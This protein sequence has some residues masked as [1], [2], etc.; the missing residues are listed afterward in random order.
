MDVGG[1]ALANRLDVGS[2]DG[3]QRPRRGH[4]ERGRL[5]QGTDG[6]RGPAWHGPGAPRSGTR[7][8]LAR[9]PGRRHEFAGGARTG[10]GLCGGRPVVRLS[11][12][13]S[14]RG[15]RRGVGPGERRTALGRTTRRER[16][17]EYFQRAYDTDPFRSRF[18]RSA[19]ACENT[20]ILGRHDALR[21]F[22]MFQRRTA[23]GGR[24]R[25][26][27]GVR[28]EVDAEIWPGRGFRRRRH[29]ADSAPPRK[30]NLHA[31]RRIRDDGIDGDRPER[32]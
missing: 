6:K 30:W 5:D 32:K 4:R 18:E 27:A 31:G 22:S 24:S 14:D 8:I 3:R 29:D 26:A 17:S 12:F 20:G 9:G 1:A 13:V 7:K 28:S 19:G 16:V 25:I 10:R 23:D 11:Q 21:F 2:G 15:F